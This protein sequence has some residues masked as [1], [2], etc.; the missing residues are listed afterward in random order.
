MMLGPLSSCGWHPTASTPG[1]LQSLIFASFIQHLPSVCPDGRPLFVQ[2]FMVT[3]GTPLRG[4]TFVHLRRSVSGE[5]RL[6]PVF[7]KEKTR[8]VLVKLCVALLRSDHL[9]PDAFLS[10]RG[11]V[12]VTGLVF[13]SLRCV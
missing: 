6:S 2:P 1:P 11:A 12:H 7:Q 8:E 3:S 10:L 13:Q 4:D 9:R 5:A